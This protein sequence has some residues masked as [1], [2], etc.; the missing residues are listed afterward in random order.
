MIEIGRKV[1]SDADCKYVLANK[2]RS[3]D[4][5]QILIP[6]EVY[7]KLD[8]NW[9]SKPQEVEVKIL[10]SSIVSAMKFAMVYTKSK[11]F[12]KGKQIIFDKNWYENQSKIIESHFN[13][14]DLASYKFN[15]SLSTGKRHYVKGLSQKSGLNL[16]EFLIPGY[17]SLVFKKENDEFF[18]EI[19]QDQDNLRGFCFS[20]F[21]IIISEFGEEFLKNAEQVKTTIGTFNYDGLVFKKYF[22]NSKLLGVFE[23]GVADKVI[24]SKSRFRYQKERLS[25]L[26]KR[27][28]VYFTTEFEYTH[29]NDSNIQFESF[30]KFVEEYSKKK[31]SI[32]KDNNDYY[33][34]VEI[35]IKS[36]IPIQKIFFGPPGSGKSYHIKSNYSDSWP[37]ITFHPELDYQGFVGAYKPTVLR[38]SKGDKITYRFVEEAFIKAYCEAWKTVE[39]YYLIIEEINRGNCAQIFGDIF[40]LLDRGN[41][42]FSEY[43]IMCSPDVRQHL[44]EELADI[45]RLPEYF[46]KSGSDDFARMTLPDNLNIL[47]TMN[48]SDQSLFPMDS[49]FKRRW[50]WHYI[51]ID[52][53]DATKFKIDLESEGEFNW[54]DLINEINK[55]IKDHTQSEDKQI[56]N[57]F[58][59]SV[60]C[61]ISKDQ[62][63]SK[64]V[65]YLWSEIYK[66]EHGS[67]NS[68]FSLEDENELTFSD[69]FDNGKVNLKVTRKFIEK[70]LPPASNETHKNSITES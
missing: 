11:L 46:E 58:V 24:R 50:D 57:R 1:L 47:C 22:G 36:K 65:F 30:K 70:F 68:V 31:Y 35:V 19:D 33:K 26:D 64:V 27:K 45:A 4:D 25:I 3:G 39:P 42:G 59:S 10:K 67:G 56:G 5:G 23:P 2:P 12:H 32:F 51:P 54:G 48:T 15:I 37:R 62:F 40:Q 66:D 20:V 28:E 55:K 6:K 13:A 14:S 16:Q 43:P 63:V 44:A 9:N 49:A 52:Y 29:S 34:L 18:I 61:R 21:K 17:S 7:D 53:H 60:D 8:W 69:F 38:T 41:D